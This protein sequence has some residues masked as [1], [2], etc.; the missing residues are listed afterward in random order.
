MILIN[1]VV[2]TIDLGTQSVRAM[3][4]D[5]YGNILHKIKYSYEKPYYSI[6]PGWAE[7]EPDVYWNAVCYV[8]KRL[9]FEAPN[10]WENIIAVTITT[11]RDT[12][13]CVDKNGKPLR[14]FILWL[15]KRRC[16]MKEPIPF[17]SS[18]LFSM[19]GKKT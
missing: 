3:L 11:I 8:T 7:Q 1:P 9:K 15:D 18:M 19:A 6:Y 14:D 12:C 13:I 10:I 5:K 2:L 17:P 4:V 16:E